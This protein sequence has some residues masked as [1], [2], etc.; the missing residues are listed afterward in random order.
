MGKLDLG[1][2]EVASSSSLSVPLYNSEGDS[3][4]VLCIVPASRWWVWCV[5]VVVDRSG[6]ASENGVAVS[7]TR[8]GCS[9]R[10]WMG[11]VSMS[12][13][14]EKGRA[15]DGNCAA[16]CDRERKRRAGEVASRAR[17]S[18][19]GTGG[20][21]KER[22]RAKSWLCVVGFLGFARFDSECG[23]SETEPA[24]RE[25]RSLGQA[26]WVYAVRDVRLEA[27]FS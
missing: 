17:A 4:G 18:S 7:A 19:F 5:V 9:R 16:T 3:A 6:P 26:W 22:E 13:T 11:G 12:I 27:G 8:A 15:G 24:A 21:A 23:E 20:E 10:D 25:G 14:A 2:V 1:R